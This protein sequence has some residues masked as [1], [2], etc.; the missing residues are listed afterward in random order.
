[1]NNSSK[2]WFPRTK[3]LSES[4]R[5][6]LMVQGHPTSAPELRTL[7]VSKLE[8]LLKADPQA[9]SLLAMSA[10]NAPELL[11]I[12]QQTPKAQWPMALVE[13]DGMKALVAKIDWTQEASPKGMPVSRPEE[14]SLQELLEQIA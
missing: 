12:S 7:L 6:A 11:E 8:A 4:Q 10:E 13:S 5:A 2:A 3:G 1:M 9:G 14:I